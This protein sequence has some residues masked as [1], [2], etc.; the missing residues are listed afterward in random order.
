MERHY[1]A[2][3]GITWDCASK[4]CTKNALT[5]ITQKS[6]LGVSLSL[7]H[8]HI[9]FPWGFNLHFLM[10]IPVTF[11]GSPPSPTPHPAPQA[12]GVFSEKRSWHIYFL[13]N[14]LLCFHISNQQHY[15]TRAP[16]PGT[17]CEFCLKLTF[18]SDPPITRYSPL[19]KKLRQ[20][21]SYPKWRSFPTC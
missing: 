7:S 11:Y 15:H 6:S 1:I 8:T 14:N 18:L 16:R 21:G 5:L 17:K 9:G 10:S 13:E 19:E 4:K 2:H 12:Q 3:S 20:H